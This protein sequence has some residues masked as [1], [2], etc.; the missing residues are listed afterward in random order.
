MLCFTLLSLYELSA[1]V[2]YTSISFIWREVS[3]FFAALPR[4]LNFITHY[5]TTQRL[6]FYTR[7]SFNGLWYYYYI[8]IDD[9]SYDHLQL[10]YITFQSLN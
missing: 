10:L 4:K 2:W 7:L 8:Q 6:S 1:I 5:V 9:Y 3:S